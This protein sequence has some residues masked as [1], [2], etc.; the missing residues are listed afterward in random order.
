MSSRS[1]LRVPYNTPTI[2]FTAPGNP[3]FNEIRIV[4]SPSTTRKSI[5]PRKQGKS[6]C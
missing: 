5:C 1:S 4:M 6:K 3:T 2:T